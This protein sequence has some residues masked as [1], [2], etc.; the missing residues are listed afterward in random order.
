MKRFHLPLGNKKKIKINYRM[1]PSIWGPPAWKFI[2]A[3]I[4][5]M[6]DGNPPDE[7]IEF[8]H[9]FTKVLPCKTCQK[10]YSEY[11]NRRGNEIPIRSRAMTKLWFQNLEK[12][13]QARKRKG[14]GDPRINFF[15]L[16][17]I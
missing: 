11:W 17:K 6:P 10:H 13:I 9:S 4:D 8:F 16:F 5:Q 12:K 2:Y 15:G 14:T 3:V 1:D 7:Y